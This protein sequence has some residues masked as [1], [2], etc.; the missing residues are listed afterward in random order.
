VRLAGFG[1]DSVVT[2]RGQIG[3]DKGSYD[4][5]DHR[6]P[7]HPGATR[8]LAWLA[9]LLTGALAQGCAL[10]GATGPGG[11]KLRMFAADLSGGAKVC[12]VPKVAPADGQ[13]SEAVIKL[14]NDGGWCGI[15]VHQ[16]GPKP[17]EA[18][19][20][21]ARPAHGSVLIHGVG[22]ETRIDYTPD[23]GF[24]GTDG[25]TVKLIPGNATV[26]VNATV[27]AAVK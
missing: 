17:Y 20:L 14:A 16:A 9:L 21:V 6:R 15:P 8:A 1:R 26:R 13:E 5:T 18:G 10:N 2:G 27:T 4:M 19:L 22:D 12:E 7:T 25:F 24:T 11:S 23:R 3:T